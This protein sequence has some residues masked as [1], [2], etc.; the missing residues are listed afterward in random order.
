[1]KLDADLEHVVRLHVETDRQLQ[2]FRIGHVPSKEDFRPQQR[3]WQEGMNRAAAAANIQANKLRL[4]QSDVADYKLDAV[5]RK[6]MEISPYVAYA[7][8]TMAYVENQKHGLDHRQRPMSNRPSQLSEELRA[9]ERAQYTPPN[10]DTDEWLTELCNQP[11]GWDEEP[12]HEAG[13]I[14]S[15][16]SDDDF[17]ESEVSASELMEEATT[18]GLDED[19]LPL[20]VYAEARG[21]FAEAEREHEDTGCEGASLPAPVGAPSQPV[22]DPSTSLFSECRCEQAIVPPPVLE[23]APPSPL[24]LPPCSPRLTRCATK[25]AVT[26]AAR[27]RGHAMKTRRVGLEAAP[28]LWDDTPVFEQWQPVIC[29]ALDNKQLEKAAIGNVARVNQ[30]GTY[31]V[32]FIEGD[33][34]WGVRPRDLRPAHAHRGP[35]RPVSIP[36]FTELRE[37][38]RSALPEVNFEAPGRM[39]PR[40]PANCFAGLPPSATKCGG[41]LMFPSVYRDGKQVALALGPNDFVHFLGVAPGKKRKVKALSHTTLKHHPRGARATNCAAHV[42]AVAV[43]R[44]GSQIMPSRAEHPCLRLTRSCAPRRRSNTTA[45]SSN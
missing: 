8:R 5:L 10:V 45:P 40:E 11:D 2:R 12:Q 26:D 43:C 7:T 17:S 35:A 42:S 37:I 4:P 6:A 39:E 9:R 27:A 25:R 16:P 38:G 3:R 21:L 31:D 33:I 15:G 44:L 28:P 34:S 14:H 23:S 32:A 20:D 41:M 22:E 13:L 36:T 19:D 30:D 1:M 24:P 18:P 29:R